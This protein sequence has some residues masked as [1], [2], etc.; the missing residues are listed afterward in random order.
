MFSCSKTHLK[1]VS[2]CQRLSSTHNYI[3]VLVSQD[4]ALANPY[5]EDRK[6]RV[7][8]VLGTRTLQGAPGLTTRSK[9]TTATRSSWPYY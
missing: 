9:D 3:I 4:L 7:C 5:E 2:H 1:T 8:R 6:L